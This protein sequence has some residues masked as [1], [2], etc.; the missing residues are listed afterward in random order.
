MTQDAGL[1][2]SDFDGCAIANEHLLWH[3]RI[4]VAGGL[5]ELELGPSVRNI[6]DENFDFKNQHH[7]CMNKLLANRLNQGIT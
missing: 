4:F 1:K 5:A 3:K 6:V 7:S 2:V